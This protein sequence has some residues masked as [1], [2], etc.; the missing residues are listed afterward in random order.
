MED[1]GRYRCYF[2]RLFWLDFLRSVAI[3][4][5]L[6]GAEDVDVFSWCCCWGGD[7]CRGVLFFFF[8]LAVNVYACLASSS[9]AAR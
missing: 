5:I 8:L 7:Y 2:S 4:R 3:G 9:R 6:L 1:T